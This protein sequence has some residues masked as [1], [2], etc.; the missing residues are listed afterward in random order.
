MNDIVNF[1]VEENVTYA[2]SLQGT[3]NLISWSTDKTA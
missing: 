2:K 3:S 1:D